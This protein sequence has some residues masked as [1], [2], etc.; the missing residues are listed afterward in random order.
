LQELVSELGSEPHSAHVVDVAN[1]DSV[2][3]LAA[4]VDQTY[5]RCDILVNNA[6][7]SRSVPLHSHDGI[8][9]VEQV[10]AT[11]F[12]GALYCTAELL[13]LLEDSAPASVVNVASVAGKVSA[14]SPGYCASKFAL[15]GWSES[16]AYELAPK[17]ITV[18]VVN[19]GFVPTEG[20]PQTDLLANPVTRALLATPEAVAAAIVDAIKHRKAERTVPRWYYALTLPRH[21]IPWLHR[22]VAGR[23]VAPRAASRHRDPR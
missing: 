5:G 21:V 15:V 4:F 8:E 17:K 16:L 18:S 6:G 12:Y 19:P 22:A 1:L 7:F 23:F 3:E 2:E 13:P 20:F 9:A 14:G 10:M 11:N